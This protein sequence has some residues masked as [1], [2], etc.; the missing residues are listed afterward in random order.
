MAVYIQASTVVLNRVWT[1]LPY[2]MLCRV[3]RRRD[4]QHLSFSLLFLFHTSEIS[5]L[6][7]LQR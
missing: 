7:G 5:S 6:A 4:G 1:V 2:A 3:Y